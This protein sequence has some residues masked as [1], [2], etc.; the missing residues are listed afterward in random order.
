MSE[1]SEEHEVA[2]KVIDIIL[3][4]G[5]TQISIRKPIEITAG[6]MFVRVER[7]TKDPFCP[8]DLDDTDLRVVRKIQEKLKDTSYFLTEFTWQRDE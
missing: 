4:T 1:M 3:L 2:L 6:K 8:E 7:D 5:N